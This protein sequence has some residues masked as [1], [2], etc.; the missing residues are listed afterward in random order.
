MLT[1]N[2]NKKKKDQEEKRKKGKN[3]IV[4]KTFCFVQ[5]Y[6]NYMPS[7]IDIQDYKQHKS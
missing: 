7:F 1:R 6:Q 2:K 3:Y 4:L 5:I